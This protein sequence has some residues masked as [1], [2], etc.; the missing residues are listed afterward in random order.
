M[1][2]S[3]QLVKKVNVSIFGGGSRIFSK[4]GGFSKNFENFVDLFFR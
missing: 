2:F 4:G 3:R 1:Y